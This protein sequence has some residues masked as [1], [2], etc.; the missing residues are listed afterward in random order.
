[1]NRTDRGAV[2]R[3]FI[4]NAGQHD[5]GAKTFSFPIYADGNN[6]IPA[7]P[8]A[9][10]QQDG[11][12]FI[13]GLCR[14]PNTGRYLAAKLYRFFISETVDPPEGWV[15]QIAGTFL[16]SGYDMKAVMRDVLLSNEFWDERQYFARY[17]WPVEFVV[18]SMKDIGWTGFSVND[19]LT[20]LSNMGQNLYDPPDVAGWDLGKSWFSTGSMLARMNFA[21]TLAANQKFNLATSAKPYAKSPETLLAFVLNALKTPDLDRLVVNDLLDYLRATGVWTG[22][23]AQIQT[24]VAGLVHLVAGT[25]EYQFV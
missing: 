20:P 10:G 14:N 6:T 21:S 4:F 1:V 19:A 17:S 11:F 13:D 18:R 25:P 5:T 8:A 7:R 16:N 24:K 15:S 2:R 9:Q 3:E 12:D 22:T 23:D